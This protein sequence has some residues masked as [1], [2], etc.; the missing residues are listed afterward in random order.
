MNMTFEGKTVLVTGG[1]R[2][3]GAA[4][5]LAFARQGANVA[6]TYVNA[7][8]KAET[9]VEQARDYAGRPGLPG[10]PGRFHD[11][12]APDPMPFIVTTRKAHMA[13]V[14]RRVP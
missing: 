14:S 12:K 10:Q 2:G 6:L 9:V 11:G 1:S 5:V 8:T 13:R 7:Q 3:L 4:T